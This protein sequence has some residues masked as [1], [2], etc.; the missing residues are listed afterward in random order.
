VWNPAGG[1]IGTITHNGMTDA[2]RTICDLAPI[3]VYDPA[4]DVGPLTVAQV[5]GGFWSNVSKTTTGA[6][7][8]SLDH[9]RMLL[10][11]QLLAAILNNQLFGST[12]SGITIDQAK[13]AYCGTNINA[14]KA[15][16][17]A[18]AAFN[19]GGD[20]G[21]FTPGASADPKAAKA[22][23]NLVYWNVLP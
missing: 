5:M 19:E 11:Q 21:L 3:G 6:K 14:I 17:T 18:M 2:E 22:I 1:T 9:A 13:A 16:A 7:R 23:A 12:P 20:T 4:V 10:L 8:S 15:A